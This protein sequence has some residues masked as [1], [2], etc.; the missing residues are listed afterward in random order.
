MPVTEEIKQSA[1]DLGQALANSFEMQELSALRE[2]AAQG[3]DTEQKLELVKA[4]FS[5]TAQRLS[6]TVG[7]RYTDFV[8]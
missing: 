8:K 2:G 3:A 5:R 6:T 1:I 4:L 7:V